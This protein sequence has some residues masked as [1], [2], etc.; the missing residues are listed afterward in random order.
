MT[1]SGPIYIGP[2]VLF[3]SLSI[4]EALLVLYVSIK[5]KPSKSRTIF[6]HFSRT[7]F[8]PESIGDDQVS[9]K[10]TDVTARRCQCPAAHRCQCTAS[11]EQKQKEDIQSVKTEVV[12]DMNPLC[13]DGQSVG[14]LLPE[15][16][17]ETYAGEL[18]DDC[19]SQRNSSWWSSSLSLVPHL[20][21]CS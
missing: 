7:I 14:E 11:E 4:L 10:H 3:I 1:D 21:C 12:I 5:M 9:E 15:L 13:A 6:T 16:P 19:R 18:P 17:E 8:T 2:V 20:A